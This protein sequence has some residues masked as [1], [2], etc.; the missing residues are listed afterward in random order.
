MTPFSG[1]GRT[2]A[3][4]GLSVGRR[5]LRQAF[6]AFLVG[7][8]IALADRTEALPDPAARQ[9]PGFG[10]PLQIAH[11]IDPARMRLNHGPRLQWRRSPASWR[12]IT[13]ITH[14]A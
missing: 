5:A 2:S 7:K 12:N 3:T 13:V 11:F 14:N 10:V 6:G 1:N 8:L 4:L 9:R